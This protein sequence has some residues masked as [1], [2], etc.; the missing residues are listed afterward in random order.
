MSNR[1]QFSPYRNSRAA[2]WGAALLATSIF[3]AGH[4]VDAANREKDA[5]LE[6]PRPADSYAI[7]FSGLDVC[8]LMPTAKQQVPLLEL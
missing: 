4:N 6:V 3:V 5:T 7:H 2:L 1:N 8:D